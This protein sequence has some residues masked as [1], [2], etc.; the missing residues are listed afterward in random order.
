MK[1]AVI[2]ANGRLGRAFVIQALKA[3]HQVRAG[4]RGATQLPAHENLEVLRCDATKPDEIRRLLS[5]QEV[6]VSAIGHVKGSPATVQTQATRVIVQ[7]MHELGITRFVDVTGTGVRFPGDKIPLIDRVLNWGVGLIDPARVRDG[8]EHVK[9]LQESD[10]QWTVLR[11]LK[12]QNIQPQP[13]VL[14]E[15]GP[16]KYFVGREEVARAMLEVIQKGTFI[17]Q[18]PIISYTSK[19]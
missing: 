14:T 12:L 9:V 17:Q 7:G 19:E 4:V 16:T 18:A 6:V 11:V 8:I 10:I 5:G 2:A 3:G 1:I 15:H 13:Y